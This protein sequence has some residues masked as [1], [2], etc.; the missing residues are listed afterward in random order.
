MALRLGGR[1]E[2]DRAWVECALLGR[3]TEPPIRGQSVRRQTCTMPQ[4]MPLSTACNLLLT[5][6]VLSSRLV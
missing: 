5:S 3:F 1:K 6:R 4:R 2:P